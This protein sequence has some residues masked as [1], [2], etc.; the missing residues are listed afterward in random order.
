MQKGD[1]SSL[2][3]AAEM[4]LNWLMWDLFLPW[5]VVFW[6]WKGLVTLIQLGMACLDVWNGPPSLEGCSHKHQGVG[7]LV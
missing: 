6:E 7:H 5:E 1:S 3:G 4:A 2:L